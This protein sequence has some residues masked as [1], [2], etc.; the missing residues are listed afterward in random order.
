[1]TEFA[2]P[3][4]A[5]FAGMRLIG[6]A[7]VART[8][9]RA[10]VDALETALVEGLDPERQPPRS[11]L[12][13]ATGELLVMPATRNGHTGC[14]LLTSTPDNPGRDRPLIQGAFLLFTGPEQRP[15]AIVDGAGLTNLRTP[16]MSALAVRHLLPPTTAGPLRLAVF[17]AGPQAL[18]HAEALLALHDVGAVTV[19]ARPGPRR[20]RLAARL[21]GTGVAVD[22]RDPASAA[23]AVRGADVICCCTSAATPLFDGAL[24]RADAVVVAI[25]SHSPRAR[26]V[27]DTLVARSHVVVES[28]ASTLREAGDVV[29]PLAAGVLW[30]DELIPLHH[31]VTGRD[32]LPDGGPRLFKGTGMPWQDLVVAVEVHRSQLARDAATAPAGPTD[33]DPPAEPD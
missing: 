27:D 23:A 3:T 6:A 16:A 13:T 9:I 11:R 21:A 20:D 32:R 22:A 14:K 5:T 18:G 7:D 2:A 17:G 30:E 24:V 12:A 1:M 15:A 8:P 26:E 28:R 31:L 25:G 29:I 10:A 19:V 33:G 4:A